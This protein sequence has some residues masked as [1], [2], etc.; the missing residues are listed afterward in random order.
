MQEQI[1]NSIFSLFTWSKQKWLLWRT[2][3]FQTIRA[4]WLLFKLLLLAG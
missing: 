1:F 3:F 4:F 2:G